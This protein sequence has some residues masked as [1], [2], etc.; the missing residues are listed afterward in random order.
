MNAS[1]RSQWPLLAVH[2]DS[3]SKSNDSYANRCRRSR[4][5]RP[6]VATCPKE[7]L[8]HPAHKKKNQ[9]LFVRVLILL[10]EFFQQNPLE[11]SRI[12]DA[13]NSKE[14]F[15]LLLGRLGYALRLLL[16]TEITGAGHSAPADYTRENPIIDVSLDAS[17]RGR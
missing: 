15:T 14:T 5:K 3:P 16:Q 6:N 7:T 2:V 9:S 11:S 12:V 8:Q 1:L 10:S 13:V 4:W 17:V